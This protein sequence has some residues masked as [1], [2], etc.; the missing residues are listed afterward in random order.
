MYNYAD[1]IYVGEIITVDDKKMKAEAVAVKDGKIL[2]VGTKEDVMNTKGENTE[3]IDLKDKTMTPGFI[4]AH[5]HLGLEV[6]VAEW[7]DIQAPPYGD[8][9]DIDSII[10]KMK[11]FIVE[12]QIKE[13][14]W[15][16]GFGY[17]DSELKELRHPDRHDLDKISTEHPIVLWHSSMHFVTCN[18]TAL[19]MMELDDS[20]ANPP[21]GVYLRDSKGKLNGVCQGTTR[22]SVVSKL[23]VPTLEQKLKKL[24]KA[25]KLYFKYGV[26]TIQEGATRPD[27]VE[28]L[29]Y[30]MEHDGLT[31][32]VVCYPLMDRENIVRNSGIP[33]NTYENHVKIGGI[34]MV[35]DGSFTGT[36]KL[37]KPY[38]VVEEG[39][40]SNFTGLLYESQ[41]SMEAFFKL[42]FENNWQTM[43]HSSGDACIDMVMDAYEKQASELGID[44]TKRRDIL[45]HYLF[46]RLEQADRVEKL[47]L[48]PSMLSPRIFFANQT[49]V[50][51][52]GEERFSLMCPAKQFVDKGMKFSLH[53]DAPAFHPHMMPIMDGAVNR[54]SV[55]GIEIGLEYK[56]SPLDALKGITIYAAYQHNDE[57]IKGSIEEGKLADLVILDKNPLEIDPMEIR[58]IQVL[59]TIKE[60]KT[61]Y[62]A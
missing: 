44:L 1:K 2:K 46:P 59:E 28:Y 25:E 45:L 48:F 54:T 41:E 3:V 27:D 5:G 9:T 36:V 4:D 33:I 49:D 42:G 12:K 32:D 13:G 22:Y 8:C 26:T 43:I 57:N 34:K 29:K 50:N 17:S 62:K 40:P 6:L 30:A 23:P 38:N 35:A 24:Q 51:R 18:T 19:R 39:T 14:D 52:Y 15:T 55:A 16:I 21:G 61:V 7:A 37:S 20:V 10:E 31:A 56:I 11:K 53:I 47:H 58:N 60:G